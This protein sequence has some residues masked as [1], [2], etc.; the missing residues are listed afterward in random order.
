MANDKT[1]GHS[2]ENIRTKVFDNPDGSIKFKPI[3]SNIN[4]NKYKK[5]EKK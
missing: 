1:N 3:F 5:E 4:L 2:F